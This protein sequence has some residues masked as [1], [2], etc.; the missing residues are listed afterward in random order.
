MSRCLRVV[1]VVG[2]VLVGG[3]T[4]MEGQHIEPSRYDT[5]ALRVETRP[6]DWVLLRGRDGEVVGKIA[7]FRG[8]LDLPAVFAA[9]PEAVRE[10]R[11]FTQSYN[12]G[13]VLLGVGIA[14][15]GIGRG[16]GGIE[17]IDPAISISAT[18]ASTVGVFLA[19]YGIKY[20]YKAYSALG[21]A[22]WWYNRELTR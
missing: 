19:A 13:G 8:A 4:T 6:G 21:K 3:V 16:I 9:S 1:C 18:A 12:R 17:D 11:E 7:A 10:A 14:A 22:V 2:H 5:Q 20:L 15:F